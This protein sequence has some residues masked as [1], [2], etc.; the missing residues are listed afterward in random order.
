MEVREE[1][2]EVQE[3]AAYFTITGVHPVNIRPSF[4]FPEQML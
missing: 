1:G 2:M 4:I 3:E